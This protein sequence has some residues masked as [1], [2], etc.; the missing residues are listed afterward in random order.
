MIRF[1]PMVL[2]G[3]HHWILYLTQRCGKARCFDVISVRTRNHTPSERPEAAAMML[4]IS[5]VFVGRLK[6][7]R[8]RLI[9]QQIS[10]GEFKVDCL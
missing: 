6:C 9:P 7:C 4:E 8:R 2:T 5:L 10:G 1:A 3:V